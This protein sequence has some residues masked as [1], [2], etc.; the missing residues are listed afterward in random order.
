MDERRASRKKIHPVREAITAGAAVFLVSCLGLALVYH[1]ARQAQLDAVR[2]ELAALARTLAVQID[3]DLHRT[4]TSPAQTGSPAHRQVLA[5]MVAFHRANPSLFY[6]YTAVLQDGHVM[7]VTGTDQVV[8]DPRD[9]QPA[10]PIMS[11]YRGT[12]PEF[13]QALREQRVVTN[14]APVQ[15]AQGTFM[16]GFAPFYDSRGQ[17][18]GVAG[19]DL[20]LPDLLDRLTEIRHAAYAALGGVALLSLAAGFLMRRLRQEAALAAAH[21]DFATGE[22][23]R[24]KEQAETANH[25][26]SAFL[27][28]MSHEIRT[29]MNGVI[30]MAS[31]LRDTPLTAQQFEYVR[32]IETSGESLLTI[33]NDILD[34]SKIEA[35]RIELEHTPFD[36]HQCLDEALDLFSAK[37]ADGTITL[38]SAF[39]PAVPG[40]ITGDATRL[41]QIFVN[42]VG[43]ALKFTPRGEVSVTVSVESPPPGLQLHFAVRDTG[44]GI[45]ADRLDRLFKSFSQVDSSTTRKFGGTGLG[46]AI[47]QRLATLMGGRMWVEST[48]GAGSTFHFTIVAG[49]AEPDVASPALNTPA[50]PAANEAPAQL[51]QRCPLRILLA[52]DNAVNLKVAKFMLQR[53]GYRAD[54]AGNGRE[55]LAALALA[56]YDVILMDLEMPEM[57]GREATQLIRA[58]GTAPQRPWIIALTANAMTDDREKALAAGMNDYLTKP[59][60]AEQL[61]AVLERAHRELAAGAR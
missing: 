26:K 55:V 17:F 46:L 6:V 44:I 25:A 10:D 45:P 47:S 22:M 42:L 3:G 38:R 28:V 52:E 11:P 4:L 20:R 39:G 48:V 57:D 33:I 49:V 50:S 8:K 36:L 37:T 23:R 19:V 59:Y 53:L 24:A 40:W 61:A 12:D 14:A 41:R 27:A 56:P 30:G 7:L 54:P 60:R 21:D 34:Y 35:G 29:P 13:F 58:A 9:P 1:F 32:T 5:P 51:A 18:A 16:S 31:L 43:N 15:D 2:A